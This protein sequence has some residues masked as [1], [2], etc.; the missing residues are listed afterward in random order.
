MLVLALVSSGCSGSTT[1]EGSSSPPPASSPPSPAPTSQNSVLCADLAAL[2]QT[3]DTIR[4]L[5]KNKQSLPD[6]KT[7]A[8][9]TKQQVDKLVS[10][11]RGQ[12]QA[13]TAAVSA[14]AS[15]LQASVDTAM[16]NPN[17]GTLSAVS[18]SAAGLVAA[19]QNLKKAIP[20][21]C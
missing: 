7:A 4:G 10:D 17:T 15:A 2:Q 5:P 16:K 20:V 12:Y 11:A 6:L 21:N 9:T 14:A 8:M 19:L 18:A 3:G 13:Q 1:G